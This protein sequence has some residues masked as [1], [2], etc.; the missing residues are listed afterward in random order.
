MGFARILSYTFHTPALLKSQRNLD[1]TDRNYFVLAHAQARRLASEA[2]LN[3]PEGYVVQIK[4]PTRSLDQSAK[5]HAICGDIAKSG[6]LWAGKSRTPAQWK[7]LFVSG[8]AIATGEGSD[9]VPG[10][11][12]EFLNL[13]E[14]TATMSKKRGASLIEYCEAFCATYSIILNN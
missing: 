6:F 13:R 11:E 3:A 14:S 7:C 2:C 9:V 4:P 8:H 10:I 12:G 1:M 5:F